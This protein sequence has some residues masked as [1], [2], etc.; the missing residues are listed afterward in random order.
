M[1]E[2]RDIIIRPVI[3]E[4]TTSMLGDRKYTFEV[5]KRAT[6]SMIKAAVEEI[7]GVKVKSVN[8]LR[9]KGKR[10]RLGVH[11]GRR[12][13]WKKAVVTLEEGH[14]IELFEGM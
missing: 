4:K 3:T 1:L 5:D 12:K 9:Y 2:P 11:E 10:R 14:Q 8:T 13:D 7:F 6:K